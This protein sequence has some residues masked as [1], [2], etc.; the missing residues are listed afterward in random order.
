LDRMKSNFLATI[1]HEL[2]TPLTSVVGYSEMLLEGLA[3]ELSREQREYVRTI[4]EKG[5]ELVRLIS[6]LLDLSRFE[7]GAGVLERQLIDP[8]QVVE[9]AIAKMQP[10]AAKKDIELRAHADHGLPRIE[11]D[12]DKIRQ[13]LVA[14]IDNALKFTARGGCVEATVRGL[15]DV[16]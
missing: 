13:A 1:S 9:L 16:D 8:F 4:M 7:T 2:R 14:I 11:A 3:G 12:A 5:G 10:A 15:M 6:S